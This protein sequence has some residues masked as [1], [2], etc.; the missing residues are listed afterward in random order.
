MA[1][2]Q[3]A[4]AKRWATELRIQLSSLDS[5]ASVYT[6]PVSLLLCLH[7]AN[8]FPL[9]LLSDKYIPSAYPQAID[10]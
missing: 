7:L 8:V 3:W 1:L 4:P 9:S 10:S 6:L 2:A 5:I